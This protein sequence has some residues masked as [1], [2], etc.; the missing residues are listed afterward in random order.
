MGLHGHCVDRVETC[1]LSETGNRGMALQS[2]YCEEATRTPP[3][4]TCP[5]LRR[6]TRMDLRASPGHK[7]DYG[8]IA[9]RKMSRYRADERPWV[10]V[11]SASKRYRVTPDICDNQPNSPTATN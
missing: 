7:G 9:Q 3:H 4:D 5:L 8:L 11:L 10:F 6:P 1:S 2:T